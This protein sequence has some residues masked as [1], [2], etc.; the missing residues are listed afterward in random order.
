MTLDSVPLRHSINDEEE[1]M[2]EKGK[3]KQVNAFSG[4]GYILHEVG[5]RRSVEYRSKLASESILGPSGS[6]PSSLSHNLLSPII[7]RS[8]DV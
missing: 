2:M 7:L 4:V 8:K 6:W 5:T 3:V 1:S